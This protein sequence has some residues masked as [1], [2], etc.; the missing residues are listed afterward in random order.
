MFE[1]NICTL[2]KGHSGR[3]KKQ[4]KVP[5]KKSKAKYNRE[6]RKTLSLLST[7]MKIDYAEIDVVL[8]K[9]RVG[10]VSARLTSMPIWTCIEHNN[11]KQHII[12]KAKYGLDYIVPR[13]L[14]KS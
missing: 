7:S 4:S 1:T 9:Y 13:T 11:K 6:H 8:Q 14:Y 12:H 2:E 10:H 5:K 3:P